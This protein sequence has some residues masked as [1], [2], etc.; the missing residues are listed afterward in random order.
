MGVIE[1]AW[2]INS[3]AEHPLGIAVRDLVE[4][5]LRE[6]AASQA[7]LQ[8]G[9]QVDEQVVFLVQ[10]VAVGAEQQPVLELGQKPIAEVGIAAD[11]VVAAAGGEVAVQAWVA[12]QQLRNAPALNYRSLRISAQLSALTSALICDQNG[13]EWARNTRSGNSCRVF[14][15]RGSPNSSI[16]P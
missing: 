4:Y 8:E 10:L 2:L 13:C 5:L 3:Q 1:T 6:L 7:L 9:L 15:R 11:G 16:N 12:P 14:S